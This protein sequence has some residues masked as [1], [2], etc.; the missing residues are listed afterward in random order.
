MKKCENC[1]LYNSKNNECVALKRVF[2]WEYKKSKE[3]SC[4]FYKVK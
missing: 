1:I 4:K 3:N 2:F